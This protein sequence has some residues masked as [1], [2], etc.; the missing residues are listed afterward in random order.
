MK[1]H[2]EKDKRRR[3]IVKKF[4]EKKLELKILANNRQLPK[5]IQLKARF[6]LATLPKNSSKIRTKNRCVLTGRSKSVYRKFK[7]S[8]IR[9]REL[10]S[11][12]CIP[13]IRLSS[14]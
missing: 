9:F 5:H 8:R 3:I 2:I 6:K 1:N 10:A 11:M 4:E 7:I 12:G 14:W 13:G